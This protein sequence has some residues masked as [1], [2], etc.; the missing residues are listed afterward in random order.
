VLAVR[1]AG[2]LAGIHNAEVLA[3]RVRASGEPEEMHDQL[4]EVQEVF[5]AVY[6]EVPEFATMKVVQA[7]SIEAGIIEE[8]RRSGC[9]LV[10]MGA[11]V[12]Y[13]LQTDLFGGLTDRIAEE[14][15]CSVLLVRRFEP[16][17]LAWLR[18]RLQHTLTE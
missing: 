14:M 1:L 2:Q 4:L 16:G 8:A 12:A 5:E 15:P 11:A 18:R 3:V 10:V 6:G 9:D 7:A 17:V 13:S